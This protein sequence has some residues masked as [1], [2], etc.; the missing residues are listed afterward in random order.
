[1]ES[2]SNYPTLPGRYKVAALDAL[3]TLSAVSLRPA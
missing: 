1:M 2:V 3:S